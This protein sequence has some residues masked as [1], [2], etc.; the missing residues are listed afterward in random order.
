MIDRETEREEGVCVSCVIMRG[1]MSEC[2]YVGRSILRS[3]RTVTLAVP[4][5]SSVA[6]PLRGRVVGLGGCVGFRKIVSE[7]Q[8]SESAVES[9]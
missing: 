3:G 1:W 8:E 6:G 5:R 7:T 2:A 9:E 4:M